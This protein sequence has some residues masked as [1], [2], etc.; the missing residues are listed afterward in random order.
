MRPFAELY[1]LIVLYLLLVWDVLPGRVL[2]HS[3]KLLQSGLNPR[4]N[5]SETSNAIS[6]SFWIAGNSLRNAVALICLLLPT[7]EQH[8]SMTI[9][10]FSFWYVGDRPSHD[11]LPN[12]RVACARGGMVPHGEIHLLL[13]PLSRVESVCF[14]NLLCCLQCYHCCCNITI[15]AIWVFALHA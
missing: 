9:Q 11:R 3:L 2:A 1:I 8:C 4:P 14:Q 7:P 6:R 5:H 15:N 13:S 12:N 10:C